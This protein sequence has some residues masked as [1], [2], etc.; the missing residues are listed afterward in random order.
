VLHRCHLPAFGDEG[1]VLKLNWNHAFD[2]G[3]AVAAALE[4]ARDLE[5]VPSWWEYLHWARRTGVVR[6]PGRRPRS[7]SVFDRLWPHGGFPPAWCRREVID[8]DLQDPQAR[9]VGKQEQVL[10]AGYRYSRELLRKTLHQAARDLGHPP[11]A[12]E[13]DRWR[14][15]RV[16][17]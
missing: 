6:R 3:E 9:R 4:C 16:G 8:D 14:R 11:S 17:R 2:D 7:R 10:P 12:P 5:A 1:D 13:Y 15:G